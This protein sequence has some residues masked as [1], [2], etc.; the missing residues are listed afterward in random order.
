MKD[1][2]SIVNDISAKVSRFKAAKVDP[3]RF[4][5]C[6]ECGKPID[7]EKISE[8]GF[9]LCSNSCKRRFAARMKADGRDPVPMMERAFRDVFS[10]ARGHRYLA[11]PRSTELPLLPDQE[12]WL[13]YVTRTMAAGRLA[14]YRERG[15]AFASCW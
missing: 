5:P 12:A 14:P 9:L 4:A 3:E 6:L 2:Q 15:G 11:R 8:P 7:R 1:I 10:I 13:L